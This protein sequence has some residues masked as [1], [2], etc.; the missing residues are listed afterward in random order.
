MCGIIGYVGFRNVVPIL[1]EGLYRL[2]YRGYDSSGIAI[3][4]TET[5]ALIS[6]KSVGRVS[7]LEEKVAN[8]N[9][10]SNLG[11]AH[12]RW[13]T[14]G[15]V[16][17][18]NAHPHMSKECNIALVHNGVIENAESLKKDLVNKGY[19]FVSETD[20]EVLTHLIDLNY[21]EC[22]DSLL[23]VKNSLSKIKG[24]FGIAVIFSD[25]PN[26]I[27]A[28]RF[29]SPLIIG[30]GENESFIASDIQALIS[31]TKKVIYLED[32]N[33]VV[34]Q[35][36]SI[37]ITRFSG[38]K[39][40]QKTE[41]ISDEYSKQELN[42]YPHFL[43]KEIMDQ[44]E[45]IEACLAGR[46]DV[47]SGAARLGGLELTDKELSEIK[48]VITVGC[49]TGHHAGMITSMIIENLVR[50]PVK[51][52]LAVDLSSRKL[53][54]S[55]D[56]MY[57]MFSQSGETADLI[58]LA[59]ELILK[60]CSVFG[61]IN[62][63]G[64][65]LARLCGKG[66]YVHA[67]TE[68]AVAST[69]AYTCQI[70]GGL[71]VALMLGRRKLITVN[72]GQKIANE[73]SLIPSKMRSYL[74][75]PGIVLEV[76]KLLVKSRYVFFI[77]RGFSYPV[78]LEGALKFKEECYVP[79]TGY[80]AGEMKHGPIAMIENGTP[81]V[82]IIPKDDE[83]DKTLIS[84]AEAKARGAIIVA[85]HTIGDKEIEDIS[86]Y[87]IAVPECAEYL[88]PLLTSLPVQLISYYAAVEVGAD[89]DKP[90]NLAK[91]VTVS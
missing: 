71:L 57:F 64:S 9:L 42:G 32:S 49:G 39:V 65:T 8:L 56:T 29:G 15:K 83:K 24:T 67:G 91:S 10:N 46:L 4:D 12:T 80:H 36:D 59:K 43:L 19:F 25:Q 86:D 69:K 85:I 7:F 51:S 34:I 11:I 6:K 44:P 21:K 72:E 17:E 47:D 18:N 40:L 70:A 84:I 66:V 27:I 48:Q 55:S 31:H 45:S 23:A 76:A 28:A 2:E 61:M 35:P 1:I 77:G 41:L 26:K 50:I 87:S 13:A 81:V 14:H 90:R 53:T 79:C 62:V 38:E 52:E 82:V 88:T 63:I 3:Y 73:L 16:T 20:T 37:D 78:A 30:L 75:N 60:N 22:K 54:P 5:E 33:I 89:P 68:I 74:D 58:S